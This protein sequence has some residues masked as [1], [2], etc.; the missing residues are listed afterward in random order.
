MSDSVD[1][2]E[3]KLDD[4]LVTCVQARPSRLWMLDF[5]GLDASPGTIFL[6]TSERLG[7]NKKRFFCW[8]H[9]CVRT[10][11]EIAVLT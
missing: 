5:D 8:E 9:E 4:V 11:L 1:L 7:W 2:L 10:G 3:Y 6:A